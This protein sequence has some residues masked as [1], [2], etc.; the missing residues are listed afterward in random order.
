MILP[1]AKIQAE[2]GDPAFT[3]IYGMPKSGKSTIAAQLPNNLIVDMERGYRFID[4]MKV[5]VNNFTD[6]SNLIATLNNYKKENGV[7][8]YKYITLDNGTVMEEIIKPYALH[9]YQSKPIGKNYTGDILDLPKGGGYLYLR[10]AFL[11]I[12]EKF[13]DLCDGLILIC[14]TKDSSINRDGQDINEMS[15]A[16]TGA[17][18]RIVAAQA[19]ALGFMYRTEKKNILT[20][21]GGSDFITESRVEHLRGRALTIAESD[22]SNK[23][24]ADWSLVFKEIDK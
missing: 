13:K 7:N 24:T 17:L 4:A 6:L 3:I 12:I 10:T 21:Q 19:D 23:V 5:E 22:D 2:S 20:F 14:H 8:K 1:E 18:S 16:L 9:L 15:I 11:N